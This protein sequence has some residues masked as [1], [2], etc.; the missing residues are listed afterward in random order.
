MLLWLLAMSF[1]GDLSGGGS[2]VQLSVSPHYVVSAGDVL[3]LEVFGEP[4]MSRELRVSEQGTVSVPYAGSLQAAGLTLDQLEQEIVKRLGGSVLVAP[5]VTLGVRAF[6]NAVEVTGQV[7]NVGF[8]PITNS[9]ITVRSILTSAGGADSNVPRIFLQ[10]GDQQFELDLS[11]IT[12]GQADADMLVKAGDVILVPAPPT[13]QVSGE[14]KDSALVP[15]TMR[16]RL[17]DAIAAA[18]GLTQLANKHSI[19]LTRAPDCQIGEPKPEIE[20]QPI[21]LDLVRIRKQQMQDPELCP[22]DKIEVLQSA[23]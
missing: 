16:M 21:R 20:G 7:R 11:A 9:N 17:T 22:N 18:G 2:P 14:V 23:F 3:S 5:Q 6:A 10:R 4:D 13:V 15:Y 1:A 8:Y 19:L 12:S